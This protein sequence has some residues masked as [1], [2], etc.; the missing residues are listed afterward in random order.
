[1]DN[2]DMYHFL[3]AIGVDMDKVERTE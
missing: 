3:Q 2:F 1:M